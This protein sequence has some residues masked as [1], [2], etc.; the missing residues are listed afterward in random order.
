ML[1]RP[2]STS[3]NLVLRLRKTRLRWLGQILRNGP[4]HITYQAIIAQSQSNAEGSLLADAPP[5]TDFDDLTSLAGN[6]FIWNKEIR[7]LK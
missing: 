6:H 1:V 3:L 4:S 5:H 2:A 7:D